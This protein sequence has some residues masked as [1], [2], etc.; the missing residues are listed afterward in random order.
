MGSNI[1]IL[2]PYPNEDNIKDGMVQR[3]KVID[4]ML[5]SHKM[6]YL[7][8]QL[9]AKRTEKIEHATGVKEFIIN[10]II[11][12]FAILRLLSDADAIYCHSVHQVKY[13]SYLLAWLNR[14]K[15]KI[16]LDAHGA[17][18]EEMVMYNKTKTS[19]FL[20]FV[21]K[22]LFSKLTHCICVSQ[23]MVDHFKN[24]YPKAAVSY[25]VLFTSELLLQPKETDV[26]KL[27]NDL[28]IQDSDIVLIYSG[29]T[30]TWQNVDAMLISMKQ[31]ISKNVKIIILTGRKDEF[32]ALLEK[33]EIDKA[34]VI[35]RSVHPSELNVFY[36]LSHYG[37]LLR[38]DITVNRVANPTKM[39]EYLQ[40]GLIPI[41]KSPFIG[42]Y[43]TMGYEYKKLDDVKLSTLKTEKSKL[44][45]E[46]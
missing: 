23:A 11:G 33:Y 46:I 35:L 28:N 10:P 37:Y 15:N 31:L 26:L 21:E 25:S 20:G 41:V 9:K 39:L 1:C 14:R 42:D 16:I 19:Y 7:N 44:N 45:K 38:D 5:S 43:Y 29:N 22:I 24:K 40:F 17:V 2:G 13:I 3:I 6:T 34:D 30:Q 18:P 27:K 4:D 12:I 36:E 8:L 32:R